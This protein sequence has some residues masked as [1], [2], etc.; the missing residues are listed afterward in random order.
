MPEIFFAGKY[1]FC[2]GV[3]RAVRMLESAVEK[4]GPLVY[5]YHKIVHNSRVIAGMEKRG[6]VF[7]DDIADMADMSRPLVLS[8]HG[9]PLALLRELGEKGIGYIDACCPFVERIHKYA[10][11][12]IALGCSVVVVGSD[13]RHDEIVG[14]MGQAEG[15]MFFVKSAAEVEALP[16]NGAAKICYASQTTLALEEAGA[17][18]RAIKKRFP[19]AT[20]PGLGNICMATS[21]RQAAACELVVEKRLSHFIV[22]GSPD[23]SNTKS[24]AAVIRKAGCANVFLIDNAGDISPE[25][26]SGAER[27]GITAGASTP[28]ELIDEVAA[29]IESLG[30]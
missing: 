24:L 20:G 15:G 22:I 21:E 19:D 9:S 30:R 1:G 8:A 29:K 3:A 26:L 10:R 13:A 11:E 4:Y 16:L 18:I 17:I 14:T 12:K 23:S 28:Q 6:V 7:I 2:S 25:M 27:L 5:A